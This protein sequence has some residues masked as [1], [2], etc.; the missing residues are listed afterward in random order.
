[1]ASHVAI[2]EDTS[3][4]RSL[5]PEIPRARRSRPGHPSLGDLV[6]AS[7]AM[8]RVAELGERAARSAL[9]VLL[10][11]E[12]G[13][14]K[15][16]LA[17]AIHGSGARRA[18]AFVT[19]DCAASPEA[20]EPP[21]FAEAEGGTLY[22]ANVGALSPAA[23]DRLLQLLAAQD[24]TATRRGPRGVRLIAGTP[25]RLVD[26][27]AAGLFPHDL[28]CRLNVL[29]IWLPPLR[30]RRSEIPALAQAFLAR[31]AAESGCPSA[32]LAPEL[33]QRLAAHDWL[34]NVRQLEAALFRAVALA[35]GS[36]LVLRDFPL[37]AAPADPTGPGVAVLRQPAG[38]AEPAPDPLPD[39]R[40]AARYG[41]ARLLDERG[42][43]RPFEALEEEVIRFAVG[44]Y[45]GHMSEVARRLG[46]GRSTL[47]R[48]LKDYGIAAEEALAP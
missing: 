38:E 16:L 39:S 35:E 46:I 5:V 43:M 21:L 22:L 30:E 2:V 45:R 44:H 33:L 32:T 10:E 12:P 8:Q 1:M 13:V 27:V 6:L 14:G 11:G 23:Q 15:A 31:S 25:T 9:P 24:D 48:K 4:S 18:R 19:L 42:E 26:L 20:V 7:P 34:G 17:R 47:Y 41:L 3:P 36:T 37:L 29:S 28:F 40:R